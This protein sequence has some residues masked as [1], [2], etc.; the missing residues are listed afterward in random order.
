MSS[1]G[2]VTVP[3]AWGRGESGWPWGFTRGG[4]GQEVAGRGDREVL[5][6]VCGQVRTE[7][8][9]DWGS[10]GARGRGGSSELFPA[11]QNSGQGGVGRAGKQI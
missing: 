1:Q 10:T 2:T 5:E 7:P 3:P 9:E 4:L 11:V 8:Q 6:Q